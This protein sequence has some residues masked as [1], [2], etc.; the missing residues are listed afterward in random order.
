MIRNGPPIPTDNVY[1]IQSA[2]DLPELLSQWTLYNLQYDP[3]D[4][5]GLYFSSD[6]AT[7]IRLTAGGGGGGGNIDD[8]TVDGQ[9]AIWDVGNDTWEPVN[10]AFLQ[11]NPQAPPTNPLGRISASAFSTTDVRKSFLHQN[12][13]ASVGT[14]WCTNRN[15]GT[16]S[17]FF[18]RSAFNFNP[19]HDWGFWNPG[20][21]TGA[22]RIFRMTDD[23]EFILDRSLFLEEQ[24]DD[25]QHV[26]GRGQ[27]WQRDDDT[28]MYTDETGAK[29]TIDVTAA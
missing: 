28:L 23:L 10:I 25:Q 14:V 7:L 26:T 17:G 8:G 2:E 20:N 3:G 21:Q 12:I 1:L 4:G 29:F 9:V 19:V 11:I 13:G 24:A 6:G 15:G 18:S 27:I 16:P 22:L 5:I